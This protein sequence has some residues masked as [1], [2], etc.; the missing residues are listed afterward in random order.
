M[1]HAVDDAEHRAR[2][3]DAQRQGEDGGDGEAGTPTQFAPRIAKIGDDGVHGTGLDGA[4]GPGVCPEMAAWSAAFRR[5]SRG[6]RIAA[7]LGMIFRSRASLFGS[8]VAIVGLLV[9]ACREAPRSNRAPV[10]REVA[11]SAS[12]PGSLTLPNRATSVKFAVIG[13]SGRGTPPQHEVAAQMRAFREHFPYRVRADARRQ[14][15]RGPG[16]ARTTTAR[17]SRSRIGAARRGCQVLRRA[18]Q[19]RRPAPGRLPALQHGRRALLQLLAARGPAG[20]AHDARRVLRARFD[21]PRSRPAPAGS[22][23]ASPPRRR[24]GRSASS[25]TRSTPRAATALSSRGHRWIPRA[26]ARQA[27][28]RRG[29]LRARAHLPALAACRTASST[30]SAAAPARC[31]PATARRRPTS[32]APS[33]ATI[34]SCWSKSTADELHFQA[35]SGPG[36]PSTPARCTRT[37]HDRGPQRVLRLRTRRALADRLHTLP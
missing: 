28:R 10:V 23:S 7:R 19:P 16:H 8:A 35:I 29:V 3:A 1:Q 37:A 33:T 36:R 15:L 24:T 32:R 27:R 12:G 5:A 21:Q 9:A 2:G 22:T 13:D 34:T 25:T 26:A 17:S 18:R 30:S 6:P 11:A 20:E 14:H 31:A 4:A